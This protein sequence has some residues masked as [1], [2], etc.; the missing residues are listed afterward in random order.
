MTHSGGGF[1][2]HSVSVDLPNKLSSLVCG[3]IT[4]HNC[5]P[6]WREAQGWPVE[7]GRP[8]VMAQEAVLGRVLARRPRK[9][10]FFR[11]AGEYQTWGPGSEGLRAYVPISLSAL[12]KEWG[13]CAGQETLI[14]EAGREGGKGRYCVHIFM[15]QC[16]C[17]PSQ[18]KADR[19][20]GEDVPQ[21]E[22]SCHSS[23]RLVLLRQNV[24]R[25]RG[26]GERFL[27]FQHVVEFTERLE[28]LSEAFSQP[29][30]R[31]SKLLFLQP[32]K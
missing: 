31:L 10:L 20:C 18:D 3:D 8:E 4:H 32:G 29:S 9:L 27:F 30:D 13:L 11:A 15:K 16:S 26:Q 6:V 7:R 24:F 5:A 1:Q 23:W 14:C 2:Q 21:A 25:S 17:S 12:N 19:Q 28:Y 22:R